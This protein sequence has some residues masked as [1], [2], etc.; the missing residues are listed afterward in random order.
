MR[1]KQI[2]R[3]FKISSGLPQ[4]RLDLLH[5]AL[6]RI[7]VSLNVSLCRPKIGMAGQNLNIA[8]RSTHG[9][10]LPGGIRDEGSTPTVT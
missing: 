5:H 4:V 1:S 7:E 2:E 6:L 8:D 10:D 9:G 3:C